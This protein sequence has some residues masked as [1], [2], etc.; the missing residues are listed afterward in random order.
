MSEKSGLIIFASA[1]VAFIL[2]LAVLGSFSQYWR[3]VETM[4][5]I[6]KECAAND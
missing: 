3:H 6:E 2:G 5:K 4:A 1:A